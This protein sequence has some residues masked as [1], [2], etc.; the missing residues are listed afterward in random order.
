[1][2]RFTVRRVSLLTKGACA[3][4]PQFGDAAPICERDLEYIPR[5]VTPG[6]GRNAGQRRAFF[7]GKN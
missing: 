5:R 3:V 6:A 7:R 4:K 2:H 1:M